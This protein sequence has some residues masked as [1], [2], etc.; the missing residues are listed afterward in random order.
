MKKNTHIIGGLTLALVLEKVFFKDLDKATIKIAIDL[1]MYYSFSVLGSLL[2]D[3]D[4][5]NSSLGKKF[6]K[7]S[8]MLNKT[9]GH[10]TMTHSIPFVLLVYILLYYININEYI[11][12]GITIGILSHILLDLMNRQGVCLLYPF[13]KKYHF[14][15][16][17]TSSTLEKVTRYIMIIILFV[18]IIYR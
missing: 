7:V 1:G 10:R 6:P 12:N 8:T 5:K 11:T 16:I 14:F 18:F 17:K 2:P 15:K 3:I 4:K 9:V 13:K